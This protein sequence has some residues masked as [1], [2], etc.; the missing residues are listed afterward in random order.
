MQEHTID[1]AAGFRVDLD[2]PSADQIALEDIAGGLSRVCRFGAQSLRFHSVAQ[3]AILVSELLID[4]G[5]PE[6][7]LA[8]LHHDSHEAYACDIP[9]PLKRKLKAAGQDLYEEV[10]ESL[11]QA[12]Y[13]SLGIRRPD[14]SEKDAIK[15]ADQTALMI[16]AAELLHDG[17]RG[18]ARATGLAPATPGKLGRSLAPDKAREAFL[19]AHR[20]LVAEA[21]AVERT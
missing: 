19:R 8:G 7:A 12:I 11:D 2:A 5:H 4:N 21:A 14:L 13:A 15:T 10:C 3:H 18:I 17:G 6:L 16:E 1:T 20:R 9:S